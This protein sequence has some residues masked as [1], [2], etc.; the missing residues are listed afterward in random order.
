M[1]RAFAALALAATAAIALPARAQSERG[2][3]T[4]AERQR[5]VEITRRLEK[6]PLA[7]RGDEDRVWLFQWIVEIPDINVRT[8]ES[9][10]DQLKEDEGE[11]HGR[12]LFLQHVFGITTFLIENPRKKDDWVAQQV[13]GLESVL[14]SYRA[15]RKAEP[16][17]RWRSLE[18]YD[19]LRREGKLADA[20]RRT[21]PGCDPA[22]DDEMGPAP[23]EAI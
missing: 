1:T 16:A 22:V 8:C 17:V 4:R 9:P 12:E 23:D 15:L 3:S 7:K 19:E 13:A 5:A 21:M 6:D 18:R 10:L 14:R 2:P 20:V 11:R